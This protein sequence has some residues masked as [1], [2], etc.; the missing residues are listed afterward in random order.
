M[1]FFMN[2]AKLRD[3]V[4]KGLRASREALKIKIN[5]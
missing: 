1:Q 2:K 5:Q 3:D 4:N